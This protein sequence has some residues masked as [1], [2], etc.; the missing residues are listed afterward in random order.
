MDL[1]N[2]GNYTKSTKF[3]KNFP[4]APPWA[5]LYSDQ[6]YSTNMGSYQV[7][8]HQCGLRNS[9]F[10]LSRLPENSFKLS[11]LA[12]NFPWFHSW[13]LLG[14]TT[15]SVAKS[16]AAWDTT[17]S[18]IPSS[19]LNENVANSPCCKRALGLGKSDNR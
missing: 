17:A 7:I 19:P 3:A 6:H 16:A 13:T 15:P 11:Y 8:I 5:T 18:L 14:A 4:R 12:R 1:Q 2:A 9:A 10:Q